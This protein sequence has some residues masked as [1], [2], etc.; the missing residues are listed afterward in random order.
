MKVNSAVI[1]VTLAFFGVGVVANFTVTTSVSQ[2]RRSFYVVT[3]PESS[4]NRFVVSLL[5]SAGCYGVAGHQQPFDEPRRHGTG[6]P[7][8]V[9]PA[10]ATRSQAR[11]FV[12]HRSM[13][14]N[15]IWVDLPMLVDEIRRAGME[16]RIVV[17]HR[18]EHIVIASQVTQKHV[19]SVR[20]AEDN[21]VRA[22]RTLATAVGLLADV[23]FQPVLYEQLGDE[24]YLHWLFDRRMNLPL[25][26]NHPRF[27]DR[28]SKHHHG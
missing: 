8:H 15:R 19:A 6:W 3:S 7:N 17:P 28:D 23:W 21:V 24:R 18:P 12:V 2:Q 9:N 5:L 1:F 26:N 22:H 16:P 25:P 20:Q 14:H 10:L 13:P 4:G 27:Q 11:C